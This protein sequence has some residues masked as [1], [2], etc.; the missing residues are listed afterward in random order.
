MH[1]S[2]MHTGRS[3]AV[4]GGCTW[5]WGVLFLGGVLPLGGVCSGVCVPRWA[6]GWAP[7]WG[8]CSQLGGVLPAG[9]HTWS[10]THPPPLWAESQTPVKTLPW[11]NFVAAG[12]YN[13]P[14][15]DSHSHPIHTCFLIIGMSRVSL[16]ITATFIPPSS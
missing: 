6:P 10:H 12:N 11:P 13:S 1:S 7:R 2:R 15:K 9:G 3:L 5:S 16:P 14:F 4:F 8:V